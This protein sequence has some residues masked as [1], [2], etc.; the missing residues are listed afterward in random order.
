MKATQ[1]DPAIDALIALL[2]GCSRQ[3]AVEEGVCVTC[4]EEASKFR[5]EVSEREYQISG[6]C[7][8]CQNDAF[9]K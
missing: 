3:Q 5:D 9:G 2:T 1:K 4:G 8:S 6:M 7:Q